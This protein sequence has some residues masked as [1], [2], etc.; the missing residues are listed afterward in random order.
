[1]SDDDRALQ[2]CRDAAAETG[3]IVVMSGAGISAE[4]G[5]PTFRGREG[6]WRVGSINYHPQELATAAAFATMPEHV[7][8]WYLHRRSVCV[9]AE[10]NE[11][12]RAL[13]RLE[14]GLA[15]RFLL[16]TQNVDGLHRRAGSSSARCYE[17]HGNIQRMRCSTSCSPE[18]RPVPAEVDSSATEQELRTRL[19]CAEC[20]GWMRP[21]VLWFDET[22]DEAHYRF[23]SSLVAARAATLLV[24]VG[25][26]GST[27]LPNHVAHIASAEGAALVAINPEPTRFTELA[28]MY[29]KGAYVCATAGA[30]VPRVVD[31]L[32]D[33]VSPGVD[34]ASGTHSGI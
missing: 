24:I 15:E 10:P 6:Y 8:R 7:W 1:V 9:A 20:G 2:L 26:T 16:I 21:H 23:E 25:T 33:G 3:L 28:S 31:A 18:V 19:S 12:H 29:D 34:H 22:Y 4:S 5:I 17:I 14:A 27:N 11:A 13:V 30:W 32:L